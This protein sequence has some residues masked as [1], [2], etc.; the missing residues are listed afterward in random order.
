M[1][2]SEIGEPSI[3][4]SAPIAKSSE[5]PGRNGVTTSP[6][7]QKTTRNSI[8]YSHG[9]SVVAQSFRCASRCR[10]TSS[11]WVSSSS[12]ISPG[13]AQLALQ[14]L[15]GRALRQRLHELDD[16]RV[17]VG[18]EPLLAPGD[19]LLVGGGAAGLERHDRLHLLA[20]A[21]MRHADDGG[22]GDR[23]VRVQHLLDLA[24]VHVEAAA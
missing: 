6:V 21:R 12:M 1:S 9:P 15:A 11:A 4:A 16:T 19:Q 5:S 10:K 17:L 8:T 14:D 24:R 22:L 23:L 13:S 7:S 20:V 3:E 18:R 2:G